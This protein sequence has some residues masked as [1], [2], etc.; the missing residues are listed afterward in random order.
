MGL[1][2]GNPGGAARSDSGGPAAP[3][4]RTFFTTEDTEH[5]ELR[6]SRAS[7]LGRATW[8]KR[9]SVTSVSSVVKRAVARVRTGHGLSCGCGGCGVQ[10]GL[11]GPQAEDAGGAGGGAGRAQKGLTLRGQQTPY[12]LGYAVRGTETQEVAAKYGALFV[13][14]AKRERRLQVDVR[15]GSYELDNSSNQ[16]LFDFD[17]ATAAT[18]RARGAARRRRAAL[19]K[20]L[21]LLTDE[22]YKKSLSAYLKKKGKE[23]YRPDDPTLRPAS[24]ERSRR[25]RSRRRC[26]IPSTRTRGSARRAHR[27]RGCGR[28]RKILRSQLRVMAEHEEREYVNSEGARLV[29]ESSV[30]PAA[31]P[32]LRLR[33]RRNAARKQPRLLL[34]DRSR[35]PRGAALSAHIDEMVSELIHCA[36]RRCWNH[37][38]GRPCFAPEAAGVLF[39]EA[40]APPRGRAAERR[41]GR[42]HLQRPDSASNPS[43]F[44]SIIDDPSASASG[45]ESL[46]GYYRFEQGVPG[47]RTRPRPSRRS[48]DVP[49]FSLARRCR[50][51]RSPTATA[52]P[53]L[54]ASRVAR[55]SNLFVVPA[56]PSR[57]TSRARPHR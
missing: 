17:S 35:A 20:S 52:A 51:R 26:R 1:S 2:Q 39:H 46:N 42:P 4:S 23:V 11:E 45:N 5:T 33:P 15:V 3:F 19:R 32:G 28:V 25:S 56:R 24:P 43:S 57:S 9:S 14:H 47:Q 49:P 34:G 44:L 7:R 21:W 37:I 8:G 41:E 30:Y 13:D 40:R 12:Y 10:C 6:L 16:E 53:P 50:A 18:W 54:D 38:R 55:M 22:A 31:R 48:Q 36:R 29:Q 27:R